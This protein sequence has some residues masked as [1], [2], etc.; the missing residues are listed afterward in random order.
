MTTVLLP[1]TDHG[2]WTRAIADVVTDVEDDADAVVLY[3]FTD[4]DVASTRANLDVAVED[5]DLDEFAARKSGVKDATEVLAD[6]GIDAAVRGEL[7]EEENGDG[8]LRVASDVD[9]DR[10]YL[11]SRK[12]S[13]TGKAVFG[14]PIQRVLLNSE[15]PVVVTPASAL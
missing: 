2:R 8:I 1:V 7:V 13:P 12:R 4:E 14:S 5:P 9:A 11:Y 15:V 3:T 6:G 10:I